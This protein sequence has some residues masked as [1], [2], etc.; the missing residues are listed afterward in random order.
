MAFWL[1]WTTLSLYLSLFGLAGFKNPAELAAKMAL[2]LHLILLWTPM[3]LGGALKSFLRLFIGEK[4]AGL[5]A[6]ALVVI[7][8]V[9]PGMALETQKLKETLGTRADRLSGLSRLV[10]LG[11]GLLRLEGQRS[12]EMARAL[13]SRHGTAGPPEP[14]GV[15]AGAKLG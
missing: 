15:D 8:K 11:R 1:A 6:M 3:E 4:R 13:L 5:L 12:E 2:G 14:D 10:L 7:L 9:L